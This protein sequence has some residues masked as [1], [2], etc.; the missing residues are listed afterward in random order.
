VAPRKIPP[1]PVWFQIPASRII[2]HRAAHPDTFQSSHAA[3]HYMWTATRCG[4]WSACIHR[5][6]GRR[7]RHDEHGG[8]HEFH[9]ALL[10]SQRPQV[11]HLGGGGA[12]NV[13]HDAELRGAER[14]FSLLKT[15]FG[16]ARTSSLADLIEGSL[17]LKFNKAKRE[18][19]KEMLAQSAGPNLLVMPILYTL[20]TPHRPRSLLRVRPA[21]GR[22]RRSVIKVE[23]GI[24]SGSYL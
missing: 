20:F 6:R 24:S 12:H 21:S 22:P 16:D 1:P 8:I 10:V 2:A 13:C 7:G 9:L 17:M 14:V 5:V 15:M 3:Y 11:P 23:R 4:R 18:S 19:E